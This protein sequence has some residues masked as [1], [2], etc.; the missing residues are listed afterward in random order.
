MWKLEERKSCDL[1]PQVEL[2]QL[3]SVSKRIGRDVARKL[4]DG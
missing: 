4:P 1:C 2:F 3:H